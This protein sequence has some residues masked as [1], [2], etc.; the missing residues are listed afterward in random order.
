MIMVDINNGSTFVETYAD[1][2]MQFMERLVENW[3]YQQGFSNNYKNSAPKRR[4][5][6]DVRSIELE[7]HMDCE[8][9]D[10]GELGQAMEELTENFESF[11]HGSQAK[12][13][14]HEARN[15]SNSFCSIFSS[16]DHLEE[17]CPI[18]KWVNAFG[19]ANDAQRNW[20]TKGNF[21]G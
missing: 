6:I 9:R 7:Y 4:G 3:A 17:F 12:P 19:R 2:F 11:M 1:E 21:G 20:S 16:N 5:L 14:I 8:E 10:M 15:I 18:S 13:P